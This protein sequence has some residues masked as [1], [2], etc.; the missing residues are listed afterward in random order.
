MAQIG[1]NAAAARETARQADGRFGEQPK[2]DPGA[3]LLERFGGR[4]P[5]PWEVHHLAHADGFPTDH[6]PDLPEWETAEYVVHAYRYSSALKDRIGAAWLDTGGGCTALGKT[7]PNGDTL[8]I[9]SEGEIPSGVQVTM[10]IVNTDWESYTQS[11]MYWDEPIGVDEL[12]AQ[13][14]ALLARHE[15]ERDSWTVG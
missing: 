10:G 15:T 9:A 7:L 8:M 2:A 6:V 3:D 13:V 1:D 11:E 14:Q 4:R 5:H 12:A